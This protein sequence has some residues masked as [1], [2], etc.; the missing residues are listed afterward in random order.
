MQNFFGTKIK[1]KTLSLYKY[2]YE[3]QNKCLDDNNQGI[4][5][6]PSAWSIEK[7]YFNPFTTGGFCNSY[8]S[9]VTL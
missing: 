5:V 9:P 8:N 4:S 3:Y 6:S 7:I 2:S 1:N